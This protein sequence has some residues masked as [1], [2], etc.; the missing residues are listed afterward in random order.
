[1]SDDLLRGDDVRVAKPRQDL[2]LLVR[3]LADLGVLRREHLQRVDLPGVGVHDLESAEHT[4]RLVDREQVIR[5][6][7][8]LKDRHAG[9]RVAGCAPEPL[10]PIHRAISLDAIDDRFP[11]REVVVRLGPVGHGEP[12]EEI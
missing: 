4:Q 9:R 2:P 1:M 8:D 11:H 3:A 5:E 7:L 12:V 10:L 6:A